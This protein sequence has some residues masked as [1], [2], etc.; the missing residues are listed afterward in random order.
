VTV[1]ALHDTFRPGFNFSPQFNSRTTHPP[2]LV[3][4]EKYLFFKPRRV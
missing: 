2:S 3:D 4:V 1:L